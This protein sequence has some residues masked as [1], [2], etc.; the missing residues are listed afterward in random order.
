MVAWELGFF[1]NPVRSLSKLSALQCGLVMPVTPSIIMDSIPFHC[2]ECPRLDDKFL[3]NLS[4][5]LAALG[6][7]WDT[8]YLPLE[9]VGSS[10][11][12]HGLLSA[13]GM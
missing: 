5:C 11:A 4:V 10:T 9:P 8:W 12:G 7:S 6:L 2:Q 13:C 3:K 1:P